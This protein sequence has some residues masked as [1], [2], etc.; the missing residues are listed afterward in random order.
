MTSLYQTLIYAII[1]M[2]LL[3]FLLMYVDKERAIKHKWRISENTL[4]LVGFLFGSFGTFLGMQFFRHKTKHLK[5]RIL[6][7]LF[8][9]LQILII[10]YG[11][12]ALF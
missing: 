11:Y 2:N 6:V 3:G 1:F 9:V 8:A 12:K 10:N 5:F 7:P 4:L